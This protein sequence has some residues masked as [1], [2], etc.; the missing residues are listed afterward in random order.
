MEKD[1]LIQ[2]GLF[3]PMPCEILRKPQ[4]PGEDNW[5]CRLLSQVQACME[6]YYKNGVLRSSKLK[7]GWMWSMMCHLCAIVDGS[8]RDYCDFDKHATKLKQS[9]YS[10]SPQNLWEEILWIPGIASNI[11]TY[12]KLGDWCSR[13]AP[14]ALIWHHQGY[15]HT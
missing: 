12:K 4:T 5:I 7:W 3:R 15:C 14:C 13:L 6:T 1:C 11:S 2:N 9:D 8:C 10:R